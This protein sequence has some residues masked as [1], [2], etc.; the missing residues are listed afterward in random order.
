VDLDSI[1]KSVKKNPCLS[2][3]C[4]HDGQCVQDGEGYSCL[5][6]AQYRGRHCSEGKNIFV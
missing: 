3:R 6:K 4:E 1:P 2:S 5:C